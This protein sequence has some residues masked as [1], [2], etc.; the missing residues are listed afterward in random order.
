[1]YQRQTAGARPLQGTPRAQENDA[2]R[3][4]ALRKAAD[5]RRQRDEKQRELDALACPCLSSGPSN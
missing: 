5:E 4:R 2:K 3:A 1:M